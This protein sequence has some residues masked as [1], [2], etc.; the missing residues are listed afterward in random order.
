MKT[1]RS[2]VD[3]KRGKSVSAVNYLKRWQVLWESSSKSRRFS[4]MFEEW[5]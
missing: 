5:I 3:E 1:W 2:K 4:E